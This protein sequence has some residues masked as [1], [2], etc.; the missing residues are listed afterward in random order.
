MQVTFSPQAKD[1]LDY[2]LTNNK[3]TA[4]KIVQLIEDIQ[5]NPLMELVNRNR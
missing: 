5:Q 2:W 4:K 3:T 1:D